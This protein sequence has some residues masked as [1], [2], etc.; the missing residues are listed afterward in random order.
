MNTFSQ[1]IFYASI[2][3]FIGSLVYLKLQKQITSKIYLY[4][5]YVLLFSIAIF[6]AAFCISRWI[7]NNFPSESFIAFIFICVITCFVS[8]IYILKKQFKC[9]AWFPRIL[10]TLL[11]LSLYYIPTSLGLLLILVVFDLH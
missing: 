8:I 1:E 7:G 10:F 11:T 3:L 2:G 6:F 5:I 9:T 4:I